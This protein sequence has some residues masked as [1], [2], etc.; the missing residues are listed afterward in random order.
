MPYLFAGLIA[1]MGSTGFVAQISGV[2]PLVESQHEQTSTQ[3]VQNH[4]LAKLSR[5]FEIAWRIDD[6]ARSNSEMGC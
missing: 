3:Q 1:S 5:R 6:L 4:Q 2:V